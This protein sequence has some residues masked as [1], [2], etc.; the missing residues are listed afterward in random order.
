MSHTNI[1]QVPPP[2]NE[3]LLLLYDE[4]LYGSFFC[5]V[6]DSNNFELVNV[7]DFCCCVVM[8]ECYG[9]RTVCDVLPFEH[10]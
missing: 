7:S 5:V 1:L 10:D 3:D 9:V 4:R 8:T 2:V 6:E